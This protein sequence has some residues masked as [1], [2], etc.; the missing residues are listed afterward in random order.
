MPLS[1]PTFVTLGAADVQERETH[2]VQRGAS[3]SLSPQVQSQKH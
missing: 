1:A 3:C 2:R